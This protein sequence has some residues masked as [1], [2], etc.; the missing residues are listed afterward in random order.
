[1]LT[2]PVGT[3]VTFPL[4][5]R[6]GAVALRVATG[7]DTPADAKINLHVLADGKEIGS[8]LVFNGGAQ[9]RFMRVALGQSQTVTFLADSS[10]P[11][12]KILLIDPVA[13]K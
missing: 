8:N 3:S 13:L 5:G 9:P 12:L 2:I 11:K 7:P 6:Y 1:M 10:V 4:K